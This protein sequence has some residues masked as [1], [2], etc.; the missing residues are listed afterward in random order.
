MIGRRGAALAGLASLLATAAR[1]QADWPTRPIRLIVPYGPGGSA[2]QVARLYAERLSAA[3]GQQVIVENKPG[4]SGGVGAQM[5]AT[6]APD[7]YTLLLS[8]TAILAITPGVRKVP[9]NPDDLVAVCRLSTPLL[10]VTITNALGAKSWAEF[11]ALARQNPGKYWFGSSGL[12][13]ITHLTGEILTRA[14]G[15]QMQ[16][17]P[18]KTIVDATGDVF[19]GRI[20]MVF[21]PSFVPYAKA[22]KVRMVLTDGPARM[23]DFPDVPTAREIGLDLRGFRERSWFGLFAPKGLPA[24]IAARISNE[25]ARIAAMPDIKEK[26]LL[27]AQ[28]AHYQST[29]EFARQVGDD[30]TFFATLLKELDIKL[31]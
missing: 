17:A 15:I 27:V 16:H 29:A 2:D 6:S 30:R 3:F 28:S 19:D 24:A 12:G 10:S 11:V 18:Y 9:Y 31:E 22:G 23:A 7:G 14:A 26:L 21:D 25:V 13:T 4:A 1:A 8:P 5:V 20:Q